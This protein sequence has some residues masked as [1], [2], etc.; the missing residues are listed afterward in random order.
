MPYAEGGFNNR[1]TINGQLHTWFEEYPTGSNPT[2]VLNGH[3]RATTSAYAWWK[4]SR[5]RRAERLFN[6]ERRRCGPPCRCFRFRS[7]AG[8]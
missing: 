7:R 6:E 3:D 1:I 2:S 8:R 4:T 5:D